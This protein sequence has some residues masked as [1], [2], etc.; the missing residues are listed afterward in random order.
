MFVIFID[1]E[2]SISVIEHIY[3]S[4]DS[5]ERVSG[6]WSYAI[7]GLNLIGEKLADTN[8]FLILYLS[9]PTISDKC[10]YFWTYINTFLV[11]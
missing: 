8:H 3:L 1:K 4:Q 6:A 5:L 9:Y 7:T 11:L 2:C 10:I